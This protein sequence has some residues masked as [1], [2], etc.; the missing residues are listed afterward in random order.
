MIEIELFFMVNGNFHME[1]ARKLS[2]ASG[3]ADRY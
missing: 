3:D 1:A 2:I